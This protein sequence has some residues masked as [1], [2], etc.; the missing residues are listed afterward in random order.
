MTTMAKQ[1]NA[2]QRKLVVT[3]PPMAGPDVK[4]LQL[5]IKRRLKAR[6]LADDVPIGKHGQFTQS[7]WFAFAEVGYWL[8]LREDTYLATEMGRGVCSVGAQRVVRDP[9]SRTDEQKARAKERSAKAEDGPHL[10]PRL[11][12][13]KASA[14]RVPAGG[15]GGSAVAAPLAKI[16][17]DT[18]GWHG[19]AHDGV[20]LICEADATL[21]AICDAVVVDVRSQGWWGKGARA[22]GG[23]A[24]SEG[25]GIIQLECTTDVGPFQKGLHFAYGHAES[26]VVEVGQQV[27]AGQKIGHAGFANAWHVHFMVNGGGHLRGIGDRDPLPF[28]QYAIR[29]G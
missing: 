24:V 10:Y 6:G 19:A 12:R 3:D 29:E 13:P 22:S 26:A 21:Y 5:A 9:E 16:L 7:T 15:G 20:D 18:W 23:H 8:G 25:D 28:V 27:R 17:G 1:E 11:V 2:V 14:A 4:S